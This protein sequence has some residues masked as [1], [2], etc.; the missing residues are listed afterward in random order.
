MTVTMVVLARAQPGSDVLV[1]ALLAAGPQ[2]RVGSIGHGVALQ[3]FDDEA[4][5][6]VTVEVPSLIQVPGE[7]QRLLGVSSEPEVPYWWIDLRR[8]TSSDGGPAH[9]LATSLAEQLDGMV[10]S[11]TS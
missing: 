7:A 9:R 4:T 11:S 1:N 6:A 3:L 10:W 8:P 5:L 2:L